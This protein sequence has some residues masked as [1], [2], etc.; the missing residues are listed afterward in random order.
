MVFIESDGLLYRGPTVREP[1]EIWHYP[2]GEWVPFR[3]YTG[4]E[5]EGWGKEI[6]EARAEALKVDNWSAEHYR[7][8]DI[9]PW[10]QRP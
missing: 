1:V 7:Y 10:L 8:Y 6:D 4:Q 5:P 3:Y 2:D 9:P